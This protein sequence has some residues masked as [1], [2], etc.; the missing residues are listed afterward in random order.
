MSD[1]PELN[2]VPFGS[3][4]DKCCLMPEA[5]PEKVAAIYQKIRGMHCDRKSASHECSGRVILDRNGVTLQCPLCGDHR[6]IYPRA[7]E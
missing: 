3:G 6:S 5:M 2:I 4:A 1:Q 7:V